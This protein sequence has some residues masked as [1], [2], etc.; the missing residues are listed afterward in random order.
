MSLNANWGAFTKDPIEHY[1]DAEKICVLTNRPGR[2]FFE[3]GENPRAF[4][5]VWSMKNTLI[6]KGQS[7]LFRMFYPC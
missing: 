3:F 6:F 7:L 1:R 5:N 2:V 4:D